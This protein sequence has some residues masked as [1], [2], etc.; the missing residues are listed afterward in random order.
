MREIQ[1]LALLIPQR[2]LYTKTCFWFVAWFMMSHPC[3]YLNSVFV[4]A[5]DSG[6]YVQMVRPEIIQS[7]V[8]L[9]KSFNKQGENV[10]CKRKKMVHIINVNIFK[11]VYFIKVHE[12]NFSFSIYILYMI[13]MW[14]FAW[15]VKTFL[16]FLKYMNRLKK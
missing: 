10:L 16:P 1:Y 14:L 13:K 3:N 9:P 15:V 8:L 4:V 11:M 6:C 7:D 2:Y 5:I 12:H